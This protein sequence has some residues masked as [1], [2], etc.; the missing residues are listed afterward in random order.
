MVPLVL[1][2]EMAKMGRMGK[3]GRLASRLLAQSNLQGSVQTDPVHPDRLDLMVL[4]V[5]RETEDLVAI[6]AFLEMVYTNTLT[7]KYESYHSAQHLL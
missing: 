2:A 3:T 4:Q 5:R 1:L 7:F 6:L